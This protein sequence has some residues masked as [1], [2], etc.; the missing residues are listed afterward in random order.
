MNLFSTRDTRYVLKILHADSLH[1]STSQCI[2]MRHPWR[3]ST[4][5]E[6]LKDNN[7]SIQ[8]HVFWIDSAP[9][10]Q[11]DTNVWTRLN[12]CTQKSFSFF[13]SPFFHSFGV[14]K[15]LFIRKS[16][17]ITQ[18]FPLV[19]TLLFPSSLFLFLLSFSS[20]FILIII[21][22][23][24]PHATS[25]IMAVNTVISSSP[26][27]INKP[28]LNHTSTSSSTT[29]SNQHVNNTTLQVGK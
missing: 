17:N 12:I 20:P 27:S 15:R 26:I 11:S 24:P 22:L 5:D 16:I 10:C 18:P 2:M 23:S 29:T 25:S 13:L 9:S 1:G 3:W 21:S 6:W 4:L 28:T 19:D 7:W 14:W 8:H